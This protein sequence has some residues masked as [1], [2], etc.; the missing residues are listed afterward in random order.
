MI[1]SSCLVSSFL[2][3]CL[4]LNLA[5]ANNASLNFYKYLKEVSRII[6]LYVLG[7]SI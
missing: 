2:L 1:S 4:C 5:L 7:N 3:L 6:V